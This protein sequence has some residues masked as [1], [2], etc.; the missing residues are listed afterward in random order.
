VQTEI[1][2]LIV[3]QLLREGVLPTKHGN[4]ACSL[5]LAWARCLG[6]DKCWSTPYTGHK[7]QPGS[8]RAIAG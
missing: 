8:Q 4:V 6:A 7:E 3:Y 2:P 1:S 5:L